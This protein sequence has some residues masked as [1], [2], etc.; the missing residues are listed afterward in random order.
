M[1]G[2]SFLLGILMLLGTLAVVVVGAPSTFVPARDSGRAAMPTPMPFEPDEQLVYEGEF[3]K[4]LLRGISIAEFTFK[5]GRSSSPS[6]TVSGQQ[7]TTLTRPFLFTGEVVSKGLFG[8]L[9]GLNFR[10][11]IESVVE[12]ASFAVIRTTKRDEQGK[13]LRTS[14]AIFDR[15]VNQISWTERDPNDPGRAPRVIT[16]QLNGASH[17]I[18]S[19]IY[20][21]RT[22]PLVPGNT[23]ELVVSDSGAVYR[24]PVKVTAE[25][26]RIKSVLGRVSAVR[27]D[28]EIFGEGR[29]IDGKGQASL[30]ITNDSRRL[31]VR[32]RISSKLGTLNIKLKSFAGGLRT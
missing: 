19:A 5:A 1:P 31:P 29:L 12:P 14:E 16:S 8:K 17:D 9:F 18:I 26:K 30:W 13:R 27:V 25:K 24:I 20:F 15:T 11:N 4:L 6:S 10:F 21:I 2:R 28:L 3:S 22:Q 23:Y 32:A 7:P